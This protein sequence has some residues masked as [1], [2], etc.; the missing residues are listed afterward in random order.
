GVE[1][2]QLY[3]PLRMGTYNDLLTNT[4]GAAAGATLAW[5]WRLRSDS[6]LRGFFERCFSPPGAVLAGLWVLW[7]GFL[8]LPVIKPSRFGPFTASS[9]AFWMDCVETFLGFLAVSL[10][11]RAHPRTTLVLALLPVVL[12]HYPP[13]LL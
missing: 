12:I 7:H 8:V 6:R 2:A 1:W 13:V 4:A 5:L 9:T 11:L 10:A 3:E